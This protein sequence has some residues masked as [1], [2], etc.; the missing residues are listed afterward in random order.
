MHAMYTSVRTYIARYRNYRMS[1]NY[2]NNLGF[3]PHQQDTSHMY[4]RLTT[5][6][7]YVWLYINMIYYTYVVV[8]LMGYWGNS[9]VAHGKRTL[10]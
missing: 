5:S 9:H 3:L 7:T 2:S 8:C 4:A 6:T 10:A 1:T